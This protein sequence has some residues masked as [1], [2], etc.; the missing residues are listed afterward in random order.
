MCIRDSP[1]IEREYAEV[2]YP[3]LENNVNAIIFENLENLTEILNEIF[4]FE[5]KKISEMRK[6]VLAYY[7]NYLSPET[8]VKNINESIENKKLIYHQAEHRSVKFTK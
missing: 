7:Q 6:N 1:L 8:V 5:E 4:Q 3:N 2:I